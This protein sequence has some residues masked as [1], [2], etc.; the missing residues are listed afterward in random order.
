MKKNTL[1]AGLALALS[2]SSLTAGGD[3]WMTDFEAAKKKAAAENKALLVDFTGSDWCGWCIKLVDEVFKHDEFKKGIADKFVLVE[4]DFPR[5]KSKLSEATQKQNAELQK[6]YGVRGF[7]T[8]LLLDGK[9][10][11]FAKTGYQA[12]GPAS[13]LKH[14]DGLLENKTKR[15]EALASANKLNGV[16]KAKA[17]VAAL[18]AIPEDY[19]SQYSDL[20][21]QVAKLDPKDETGFVAKQKTKAAR[22][23][24]ETSVRTAMRGG[25]ADEAIAKIDA[26]ITEHKLEGEAKQELLAMKIN[27]MLMS[28][29]VEGAEKA[30]D[31][32]IAAAPE[33]KMGQNIKKFKE[34]RFPKIKEQMSK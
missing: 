11:P 15:D 31:E 5:D 3:G 1:L 27:P 6:K 34:T 30:I 32:A 16:A 29:N 18:D 24:L 4:L 12:G 8:I 23:E 19:H 22:K 9:G 13:Y 28:K 20:I 14:L 10:L 26:F 2:A 17:L 33:S 21:A 25:N 7:P